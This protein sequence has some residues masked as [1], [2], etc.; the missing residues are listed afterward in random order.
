[1]ANLVKICLSK[2]EEKLA[3]H[4]TNFYEIG[5]DESLLIRA[6]ETKQF[7]WLKHVWVMKKHYIGLR[8]DSDCHKLSLA[9]LFDVVKYCFEDQQ[10][11]KES[12]MVICNWM[13][14]TDDNMMISLLYHY[15]DE[16]AL[17]FIGY[18]YH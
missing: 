15:F 1:M 17:K 3:C 14:K 12:A 6:I 7:N 10:Q 8:S 11:I 16:V 13:L 4:L 9:H 5:I 2:G 18:Y